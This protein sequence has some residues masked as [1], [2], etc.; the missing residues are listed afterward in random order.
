MFFKHFLLTRSFLF[1]AFFIVAQE[2]PTDYKLVVF[3]GSDWCNN[4]IRFEKKVL[5]NKSFIHFTD[6]KKIEI[7]RIDF[8]Q[9][10]KLDKE[11]KDYNASI[12]EKYNFQGVFP[13]ILL[14]EQGS[15]TVLK[16]NYANQDT[17]EF[18]SL[19]K[20]KITSL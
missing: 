9:R 14:V 19:L 7:E 17:E 10:K 18:I 13:T 1:S 12:A 2:K 5:S 15:E 8:P 3:E 20:S 16:I 6:V 11:I 4:C